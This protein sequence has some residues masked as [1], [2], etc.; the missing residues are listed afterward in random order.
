MGIRIPDL[1]VAN[2]RQRPIQSVAALADEPQRDLIGS[3][4]RARG[5]HGVH[6]PPRALSAGETIPPF[7]GRSTERELWAADDRL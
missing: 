3:R 1:L 6:A 7:G 4:R 2:A 5:A